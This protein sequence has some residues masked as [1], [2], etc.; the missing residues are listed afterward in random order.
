MDEFEDIMGGELEALRAEISATK[1]ENA[2]LKAIIIE[3]DL[4]DE[5][6]PID[7]VV[8]PE[9]A[10]QRLSKFRNATPASA[11]NTATPIDAAERSSPRTSDPEPEGG[12]ELGRIPLVRIR[13]EGTKRV[14]FL[15][16]L[17]TSF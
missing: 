9:P 8:P 11:R 13:R 6:E 16:L 7:L 15:A 12:S 10:R 4:E 1:N 14:P 17:L 3:N 2:K 5:L